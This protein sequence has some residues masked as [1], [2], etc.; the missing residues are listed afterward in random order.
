MSS[1]IIRKIDEALW[2]KVKARA[3]QHGHHLRYVLL[4]LLERYS[5][6]GLED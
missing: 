1:Y 5:E 4:K 3:E 2:L 6:K